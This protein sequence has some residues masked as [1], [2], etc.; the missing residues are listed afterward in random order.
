MTPLWYEPN[1]AVP[2][3]GAICAR[4]PMTTGRYVGFADKCHAEPDR[5]A[6][7]IPSR[8]PVPNS[9]PSAIRVAFRNET[10]IEPRIDHGHSAGEMLP[11]WSGVN[12]ETL[13]A[14]NRL[15]NLE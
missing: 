2:D 11:V 15:D 6:G 3:P 14:Y 12:R 1:V 9:G 7:E 13:L 10:G 5:K 8:Y 4:G